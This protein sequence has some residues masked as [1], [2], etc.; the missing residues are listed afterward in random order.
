MHYREADTV[1]SRQ[2]RRVVRAPRM[3]E[4]AYRSVLE[5]TMKRG[6]APPRKRVSTGKL[7]LIGALFRHGLA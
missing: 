6:F 3:M 2:H 5:R 1:M 7:R 4:A